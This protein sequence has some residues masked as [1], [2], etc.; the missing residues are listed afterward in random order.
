M[1]KIISAILVVGVLGGGVWYFISGSAGSQGA[2]TPNAT[3]TS[4]SAVSTESFSGE[5]SFNDI[6]A[7]GG[8]WKCAFDTTSSVADSS[9]VVYIGGE[10]KMRGDFQTKVAQVNMNIES[11]M[12]RDGDFMY[13]W[14]SAMPQGIKVAITAEN[15]STVGTGATSGNQSF[16]VGAKVNWKCDA[17]PTDESKFVVPTN[18]TFQTM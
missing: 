14:S 10:K 9:G 16:D 6:M 5:A 12:V 15:S 4:S 7:R 3:T 11:H 2:S 8:S 18:I 1:S 13:T 17:W